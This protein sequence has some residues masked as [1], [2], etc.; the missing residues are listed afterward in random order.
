M[1]GTLSLNFYISIDLCLK[2][3]IQFQGPLTRELACVGMLGCWA[4]QGVK[5]LTK[6]T[7]LWDRRH[8]AYEFHWE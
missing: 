6:L 7:S 8:Q 1:L 5:S 3:E 4:P 2:V